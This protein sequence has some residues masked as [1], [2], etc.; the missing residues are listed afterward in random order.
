MELTILLL[1][2]LVVINLLMLFILIGVARSMVKLFDWLSGDNEEE[3]EKKPD[4]KMQAFKLWA[5]QMG[6]DEASLRAMDSMM[7]MSAAP[8][9]DGVTPRKPKRNTLQKWVEDS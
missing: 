8:N 3:E 2:I 6:Y 1:T 7:G 9:W 5:K 4:P